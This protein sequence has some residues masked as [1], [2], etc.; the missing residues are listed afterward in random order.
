MITSINEFRKIFE[1]LNPEKPLE[2][3]IGYGANPKVAPTGYVFSAKRLT[4]MGRKRLAGYWIMCANIN[5]KKATDGQWINDE[6]MQ[7]YQNGKMSCL[8]YLIN[9][10]FL[11]KSK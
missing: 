3:T 2:D 5:D 11:K 4:E 10:G 9:N 6:W 1:N 7:Q 8:S